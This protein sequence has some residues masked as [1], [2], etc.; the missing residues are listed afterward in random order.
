MKITNIGT[1]EKPILV[2]EVAT[3]PAGTPESNR[4][5]SGIATG[6]TVL[7]DGALD[8]IFPRINDQQL[9]KS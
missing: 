3:K 5:W 2:P 7:P 6:S 4:F 1:P 8:I 9:K